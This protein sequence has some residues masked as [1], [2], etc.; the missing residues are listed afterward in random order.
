MNKSSAPRV[1]KRAKILATVGPATDSYEKIE[2]MV[3]AGVNGFRL[4]FSHATEEQAVRWA[5]WIRQA[6][7]ACEKPVAILQ[8]LQGPKIRLGD[9]EGKI[10]VHKDQE[11]RLVFKGRVRRRRHLPNSVRPEQEG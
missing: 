8:D 5:A 2:E 1:F 6:S 4:N 9:F 10:A 11:L 3:K 7:E